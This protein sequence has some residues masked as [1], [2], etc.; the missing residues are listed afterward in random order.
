M[1]ENSSVRLETWLHDARTRT[2]VTAKYEQTDVLRPVISQETAQHVT[3][4][5]F[6]ERWLFVHVLSRPING[7]IL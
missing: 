3:M 7:L 5:K 1:T 4:L 6:L 2:A